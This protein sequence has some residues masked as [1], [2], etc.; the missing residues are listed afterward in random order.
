MFLLVTDEALIMYGIRCQ[1]K[2]R[3][4]R[5][6][7]TFWPLS[8]NSVTMVVFVGG[9]GDHLIP[10]HKAFAVCFGNRCSWFRVRKAL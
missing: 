5:K 1:E 8:K 6:K 10:S 4:K 7:V 9:M 2:M 3:E